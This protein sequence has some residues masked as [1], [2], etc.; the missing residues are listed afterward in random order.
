MKR[1]VSPYHL[2]ASFYLPATHKNLYAVLC[3]QKYTHL[4]SII[5]DFEDAIDSHEV[6]Q[7]TYRFQE[8]LD[9]LTTQEF[10]VFVRPRDL[11]H[12]HE[13]LTLKHI[14]KMDGFVLAKCDTTNMHEY[15]SCFINK[16]FW[17]MP[18]LE[19]KEVFES[20]K[21][22]SMKNFFIEHQEMILSLRFG[23]EDLSSSLGLKRQCEDILY[24]LHPVKHLLSSVVLQFKPYGFNIT[25]PVFTCFKNEDGLAKELREDLKMG[26]FGKT[27]IHPKQVDI[28]HNAYA[29][30]KIE[31]EQARSVMDVDAPAIIASEGSMLETIPH[32]RWATHILQREK[33]YGIV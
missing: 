25:A 28:V 29:V 32:R 33:L 30:K 15:F 17:L 22:E 31:L 7:S 26:L 10:L 6:G 21:L 13:L 5:I 8:I 27:V 11:A 14:D 1:D 18:V 12:L 4:R 20:A 23:G 16:R 24:D 3:Q 9:V 2:G 19:S